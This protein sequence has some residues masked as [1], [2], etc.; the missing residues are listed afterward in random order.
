MALKLRILLTIKF[1]EPL[2]MSSSIP[3]PTASPLRMHPM[4]MPVAE[5]NRPKHL[6]EVP[7]Q[8]LASHAR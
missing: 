4:V 1:C 3:D 8:E 6:N 7:L 2:V 5:A